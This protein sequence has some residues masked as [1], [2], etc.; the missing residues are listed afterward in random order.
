MA[1]GIHHWS[2]VSHIALMQMLGMQATGKSG[3]NLS[4]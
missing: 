4:Y 3:R 2:V 1:F